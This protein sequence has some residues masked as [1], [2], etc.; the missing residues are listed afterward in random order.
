MDKEFSSYTWKKLFKY[1]SP[2]PLAPIVVWVV[3]AFNSNQLKIQWEYGIWIAFLWLLA[4]TLFY[5]SELQK[6]FEILRTSCECKQE[7]FNDIN[8]KHSA[9]ST[10]FID[11][12]KE[13]DRKEEDYKNLCYLAQELVYTTTQKDRQSKVTLYLKFREAHRND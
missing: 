13:L 6:D 11:K 5:I 1:L 9:L 12:S 2:A 7:E 3:N 10:Q 4:V 8:Q